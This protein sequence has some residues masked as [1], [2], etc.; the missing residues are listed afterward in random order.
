[1][2]KSY[3]T[4]TE[5][6]QAAEQETMQQDSPKRSRKKEL[7]RFEICFLLL[8][9]ALFL[10][11]ILS[12]WIGS[13]AIPVGDVFKIL[14][15]DQMKGEAV[16]TIVWK[17]RMPRLCAAALLGGALGV[18]G[19]L[20]QTY[21]RNP[22]A[23]PFVLGISSGAKMVL[24]FVTV[25]ALRFW[26][27]MGSVSMVAASFLGALVSMGF[28]LACAGK[29]KNMSLLLVIGIM[30]GYICSAVTDFIITFAE[31]AEIAHLTTWS[32]GSF[33][34]KDW[35]DVLVIAIVVAIG[36]A[37]CIALIKP[38]SAFRLGEG[39]AQSMGLNV[40]LFRVLI[41]LLSSLL[42]A[43]V[44][45]FAGPI[46]FVGIAVPHL[47]KVMFSS[48]K[49]SV[50]LPGSFLLGAVF[51]MFCDLIARTAFAPTE[52]AISTVT[53]V[54]GAPVVIGML[55]RGRKNRT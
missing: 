49:P 44:V 36:F 12:I 43:C 14:F 51:C 13:V 48:S 40:K 8:A 20:I 39:Y 47:C 50:I 1:M 5:E 54:F 6:K 10:M 32:M 46:S 37:G 33:S 42:S 30:I 18:S 19:F 15:S 4:K 27:G 11:V 28:V 29:V 25:I 23:S 21:F 34:G 24:A 7:F 52:M 26:G 41:I 9:A 38:I 2:E 16:Y 55:L 3:E 45:A 31:D 22:I 35:N 53:A 17:S